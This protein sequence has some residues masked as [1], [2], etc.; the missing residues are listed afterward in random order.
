MNYLVIGDKIQYSSLVYL[1][2]SHYTVW[3]V[4]TSQGVGVGEAVTGLQSKAL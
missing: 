1:C 3:A 4:G 2:S